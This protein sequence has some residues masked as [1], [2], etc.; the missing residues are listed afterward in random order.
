MKKFTRQVALILFFIFAV[1]FTTAQTLQY[2]D[3]EGGA[4][5][6]NYTENPSAYNVSG[7]IW[8]VVSSLNGTSPSNGTGMLGMQDLDNTNGGGSIEHTLSFNSVDVSSHIGVQITFDYYSFGL[9]N[10]DSITYEIFE[11]GIGQGAI[12]LDK[13]TQGWRTIS[14][15]IPDGVNS[16]YLVLLAFQD[17]GADYI[18]WDNVKIIGTPSGSPMVAVSQTSFNYDNVYTGTFQSAPI[19]Y[20]VRG[21]N[22]TADI[23]I[24][25]HAGYEVSTSCTSGF[26][27]SITLSPTGGTIGETD[28]FAIFNPTSYGAFTGDFSHTSAGATTQNISV[29]ETNVSSNLPGTYYST[30]VSTGA[31]LKTELYNIIKGHTVETYDALYVHFETTDD[32]PNTGKIWDMYSDV[33]CGTSAYEYQFY[34]SKMPFGWSITGEGEFFHREHTFPKSWWGYTDGVGDDAY[35]DIFHIIPADGFSNMERLNY[36]YGEVSSPTRTFTNG[37]KLG[38]NTF[39]SYGGTV[40]EPADEYKGDLARNLLYTVTRYED[41]VAG[42]E[43]S[44]PMGDVVLDGL[45]YPAYEPWFIDLLL[46]WHIQDPVSQKE[47]NRNDDIY[48]IQ[49]NRNPYID[50][51][52]YA[53]LVWGTP[54][55]S[56]ITAG[57]ASPAT[58]P[59]ITDTQPEAIL[60]FEFVYTDDGATPVSDTENTNFSQIIISQGIGN[61]TELTDWTQA[62]AGAELSDGTTTETGT[63]STTSITFASLAFASAGDFGFILDN[64]NKT[65]T[66]KIWLK[67]TLGG[68]LPTTID[69]KDFVFEVLASG[70]TF[71]GASSLPASGESENSID[72]NNVVSVTSTALN[73]IQQ[74]SD[75]NVNIA[76]LP[77]VEIE[78][79]DENGNRDLD[80]TDNISITST[81]TMTVTP[82]NGLLTSGLATFS[83]IVHSQAG[84]GL[85]ITA[86]SGAIPDVDSNTFIITAPISEDSDIITEA[87]SESATVPSNENTMGPLTSVQGVQVWEFTIRDG[88][89]V[90]DA[91]EFATIVNQIVITQGA[92]NAMND[93]DDAILSCDLFN[94]ALH[95]GTAVIANSTLTF[96][97]VPLISIPDNSSVT[98]T[99][100]LSVQLNANDL[101]NNLDGDDFVFKILNANAIADAAGSQFTTFANAETVNG[102]NVFD[103]AT[104]KL[105][106]VQE[107][108]NTGIGIGMVPSVTIEATDANDNRDID[109][110]GDIT[111]TSTGTMT[112]DPITV[113]AVSGLATFAGIIHTVAGTGYT[114]TA[115]S[116]GLIDATSTT[117]DILDITVLEAGDLMIVAV[118]TA[119]DNTSP[120]IT[121]QVSGNFEE[122]TFISFKE[123]KAGTAID[124]TDNGWERRYVDQW[125]GSEGVIR[126]TRAGSSTDLAAGTS[127]TVVMNKASGG[128]KVNADYDVFVNG[129]DEI[130]SGDWTITEINTDD[131]TGF[132]MNSADDIWILQNGDWDEQTTDIVGEDDMDDLYSGNVLYGWTATGWDANIG[133]VPSTWTTNGSR[134]YPFMDCFN[135]D[136]STGLLDETG[137]NATATERSKVKYT[138]LLTAATKYEWLARVN[139]VSN[140]T[141]YGTDDKYDNFVSH[142]AYQY[143]QNGVNIVINAGGFTAGVWTGAADTD[144]F[145]CANWQNLQVPNTSTNVLLG[146]EAAQNSV[147]DNTTA[148]AIQY[149]GVAECNDLTISNQSLLIEADSNNKLQV[150]GNILIDGTGV[151]D[152]DDG[153][154]TVDGQIYL[155]GNWS[156]QGDVNSF[157]QGDETVHL[158]GTGL[159]TISTDGTFAETFNNIIANNTSTTGIQQN[160]DV[161]IASELTQTLADWDLNTSDLTLQGNYVQTSGMFI[162]DALSDMIIENTGTLSDISFD[163]DFNLNNFTMNRAGVNAN[164]VTNLSVKTDMTI[165][166]GSVTLTA[167]NQ[168]DVLGTLDN[169]V[170]TTGLFIKSDATG[171]ASLVHNTAVVNATTERHLTGNSWHYIYPPLNAIPLNQMNQIDGTGNVNPNFYHYDETTTDYW[172]ATL[173]YENMGWTTATADPVLADRGYALFHTAELTYTYAG[174]S[175]FA[176]QKD[177]T[178]SYTDTGTGNVNANGVTADWDDFEGWC[179]VGNPYPSAFDWDNAGLDKTNIQNVVYYYD[180]TLDKYKYHGGGTAFSQGISI[181]GG[182]QLIPANQAIFIKTLI[183]GDG[184]NFS[185]PNSARA[186]SLQAFWRSPENLPE[187]IIRI[188]IEKDGYFDETVIRTLSAESLV[189]DNFDSDYDA[190]KLFPSDKTKPQLYSSDNID[191]HSYALNSI[192]H[193]VG[194]KTIPLQMHIA[195]SGTYTLHTTE[196][197]FENTRIYLEDKVLGTMTRLYEH[198]AYAFSQTVENYKNRFVLHFNNNQLPVANIEIPDQSTNVLEAY[199]YELP[200]S[201]FTDPDSED[202]LSYSTTLQD[203]TQIPTWLEFDTETLVFSGYPDIVQVLPLKI[204]ATDLFG[205]T[206]SI[207]YTLTVKSVISVNEFENQISVYPNPVKNRLH[208]AG[209]NITSVKV[210]SIE[211]KLIYSATN[212]KIINTENWAG[213]VYQVTVISDNVEVSSSI[214][215]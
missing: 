153:T 75:T 127:V 89:G 196:L 12:E 30:A 130:D 28:V 79:V 87:G 83:T 76:M 166:G 143:R 117:Y 177:F 162:G 195:E 67:S 208:I 27:S 15:N 122:F 26:A 40:Y 48:L 11:D 201:S 199:N 23:T 56:T 163:T 197:N 211:G 165:S 125:G 1:N 54:G 74:P 203:G 107:P 77:V 78:A 157:L 154:A 49:G 151:L 108:T 148:L 159:Q 34:I 18:C 168:Y 106:F 82:I 51:P 167:P 96:T 180:D 184:T 212:N 31:A 155:S 111:I 207:N 52:A 39:G 97:G 29:N 176:G 135:T 99:M 41:I 158:I 98:L 110:N 172:D 136:V 46:S 146:A 206:A 61:A 109:F 50:N 140:W 9:D 38:N 85:I 161:I 145:E 112:G 215:K 92:G 152:M 210:F 72:G 102:T 81:G 182:S 10:A 80:H 42:W 68:T 21:K 47:K 205:A 104:T 214:L 101:G 105:L 32:K 144:W 53:T 88:G 133:I 134:L 44:S 114:M 198:T 186:H 43:L 149:G 69:G 129:V 193:I 22:L 63:V 16:T 60:N 65:Y 24:N 139:N 132:N 70:F 156:N 190:Y 35:T 209:Q 170:G 126:L 169:T 91:D 174:G 7:D 187:Q 188:Q 175:L 93:W 66:L 131:G 84:T 119:F 179:L 4:D 185:V 192:S 94:G 103:I 25:A 113:T 137:N 73:I 200:V 191:S 204:I 36:P 171:T 123:I 64:G 37:A 19:Y 58:I 62:I 100:R 120:T 115:T 164:L 124:F 33:A 213:G 2:Q 57:T 183:T 90:A 147:I 6:W 181:G 45:T 150:N 178:L 13:N 118:N 86:S 141:G 116:A 121:A 173:I 142:T 5:N 71:E 59:S 8:D 194:N 189:S 3:F 138:G 95:V 202:V 20:T 55:T 17:G 160:A 14:A 128:G